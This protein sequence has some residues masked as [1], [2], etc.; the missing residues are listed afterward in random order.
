MSLCQ[1]H[2]FVF[3]SFFPVQVTGGLNFNLKKVLI[4]ES[5]VVENDVI[6]Y[7]EKVPN[8]FLNDSEEL[9]LFEELQIPLAFL[10]F[11]FIHSSFHLSGFQFV[12]YSKN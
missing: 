5:S 1:I 7:L 4:F 11:N 9:S 3:F 10:K 2:F 6:P 12:K 8:V